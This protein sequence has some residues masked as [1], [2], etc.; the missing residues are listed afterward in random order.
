MKGTLM[1]K[2]DEAY[3]IIYDLNERAHDESWDTWVKADELMES[4][5]EDAEEKAE[6]LRDEASAE[7][8]EHFRNFYFQ[9][10]KIDKS[11]VDHWIKNNED[12][13][14]EFKGFFGEEE[15]FDEFG[16]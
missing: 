13:R 4:E 14:D 6:E 10:D 11:S 12:F 1:K 8:A 7:Q 5:E 3:S 16:S 15:F 2:I 9:L